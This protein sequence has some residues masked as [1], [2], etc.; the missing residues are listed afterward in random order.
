MTIA[1]KDYLPDRARLRATPG[2]LCRGLARRLRGSTTMGT[3][4]FLSALLLCASMAVYSLQAS[5]LAGYNNSNA[6]S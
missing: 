5:L 6:C 1:F 2:L 4:F 3:L